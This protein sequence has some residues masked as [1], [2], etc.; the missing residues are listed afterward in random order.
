MSL[1]GESKEDRMIHM[2]HMNMVW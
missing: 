2:S 1:S